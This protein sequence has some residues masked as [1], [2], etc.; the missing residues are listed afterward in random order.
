MPEMLMGQV[1]NFNSFQLYYDICNFETT[2]NSIGFDMK[3]QILS[4]SKKFSFIIKLSCS[5]KIVKT[6]FLNDI[7]LNKLD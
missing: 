6:R 4:F 3:S 2:I 1:Y 5:S 7:R